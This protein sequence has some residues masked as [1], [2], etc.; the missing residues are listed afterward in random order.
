[1]N[2]IIMS[3]L[4]GSAL[5][6][7]TLTGSRFHAEDVKKMGIIDDYVIEGEVLNRAISYI[8]DLTNKDRSTMRAIKKMHNKSILDNVNRS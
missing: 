3:R 7:I 1:M 2:A 8:A 6:D 4:H 5:R